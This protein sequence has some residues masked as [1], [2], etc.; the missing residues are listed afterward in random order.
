[1]TITIEVADFI[2]PGVNLPR[3]GTKPEITAEGC[4]SSITVSTTSSV[5]G[6]PY[7]AASIDGTQLLADGDTSSLCV[8]VTSTVITLLTGATSLYLDAVGLT[9]VINIL[10]ITV[11]LVQEGSMR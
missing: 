2:V 4:I 8:P 9:P 10:G 3:T 1:M 11:S 6:T 7:C 5:S